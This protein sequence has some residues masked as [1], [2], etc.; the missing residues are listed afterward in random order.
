MGAR[1]PVWIARCAPSMPCPQADRC[2]RFLAEAD[3]F[4]AEIDASRCVEPCGCA[5]FV[6]QRALPLLQVPAPRV[7]PMSPASW[8]D[9]LGSRA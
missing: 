2:A 7:V 9:A 1:L 4:H 3:D 5:L 6:D 8:L